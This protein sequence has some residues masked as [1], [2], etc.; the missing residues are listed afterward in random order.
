MTILD[1]V[2]LVTFALAL[3]FWIFIMFG[4]KPTINDYIDEAC[5]AFE[6][7]YDEDGC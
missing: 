4:V 7:Y 3:I 2:V 5:D 1:I 6:L